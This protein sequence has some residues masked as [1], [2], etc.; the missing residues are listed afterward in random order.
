MAAYLAAGANGFGLGSA[1]YK[2]G[3]TPAQ[4]AANAR[5]FAAACAALDDG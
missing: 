4:V 1:L 5:A 3:M 2:A